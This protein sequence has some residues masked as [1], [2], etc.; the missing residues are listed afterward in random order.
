[1]SAGTLALLAGLFV[2]PLAFLTLGHRWRRRGP[3]ARA[4]FWGGL[5]GY[6]LASCVALVVG[7]SPAAEWSAGDT[8]RGALGFWSLLLA[9]ALGV[10]VALLLAGN[11]RR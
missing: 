1:M 9:P 11:E 6:L 5:T 8:L 2:I 10:A 7:M 4:A 3:R